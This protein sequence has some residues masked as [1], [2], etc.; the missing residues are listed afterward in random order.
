MSVTFKASLET[1]ISQIIMLNCLRYVVRKFRSANSQLKAFCATT[2]CYT[3]ALG[4]PL[5]SIGAS[6][7][8]G[9]GVSLIAT[10]GGSILLGCRVSLADGV[11]IVTQG[12][13]IDIKDDVFIGVGSIIVSRESVEI[14]RDSL[15]AEYVV[16]RDQDHRTDAR[17]L[18]LA[19]FNSSPIRIGNDVWIGCKATVLRGSSIGDRCVIGAHALVK[20]TI[21]EDMLAVGVPARVI[22]SGREIR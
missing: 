20:S 4:N 7:T 5:I 8:F 14:G 17:P 13:R 15:I 3:N 22:R 16:I 11:Q 12:G 18:R 9:R 10:D 1:T 6:C 21:P 2:I 19:G